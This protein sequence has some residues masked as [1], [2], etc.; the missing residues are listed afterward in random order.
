MAV[1]ED[2]MSRSRQSEIMFRDIPSLDCFIRKKRDGKNYPGHFL[3][4]I[5]ALH[6]MAADANYCESSLDRDRNASFVNKPLQ[7]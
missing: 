2:T 5:R 6:G 1:N 4:I 3:R 7:K